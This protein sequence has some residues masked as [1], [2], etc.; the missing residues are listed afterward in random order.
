MRG[1]AGGP[2]ACARVCPDKVS[3]SFFQSKKFTGMFGSPRR[4][5]PPRTAL[6]D[7]VCSSEPKVCE[8]LASELSSE[9]VEASEPL[10]SELSSH[11]LKLREGETV[12]YPVHT[13]VGSDG[14][15]HDSQE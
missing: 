15:V 11:Y 9:S 7:E 5:L 8:S 3:R 6:E 14:C 4:C 12:G 2:A 1:V 13:H 10:A